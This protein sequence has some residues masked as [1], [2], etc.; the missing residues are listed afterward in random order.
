MSSQVPLSDL[1]VRL[2]NKRDGTISY[3]ICRHG[4]TIDEYP[5]QAQAEFIADYCNDHHDGDYGSPARK[6]ARSAWK[7]QQEESSETNS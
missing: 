7:K 2:I 3:A 5:S 4:Y 1:Y 6:A